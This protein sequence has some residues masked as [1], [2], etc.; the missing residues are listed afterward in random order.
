MKI[1]SIIK[2]NF[3]ILLRNKSS[4][5][6]VLLGPLLIILI[7][8][9]AFSN[10]GSDYALKIGVYSSE[11]SN[12]TDNFITSLEQSYEINKLNDNESCINSVIKGDNNACLIFPAN[13]Q[14]EDETQDEIQLYIDQSRINLVDAIV[15]RIS[16][17]LGVSSESTSK[18]LTTSLLTAITLTKDEIEQ[19]LLKGIN[20]KQKTDSLISDTSSISSQVNSMDLSMGS[21]DIGDID[22]EVDTLYSRA[23][24]IKTKALDAIDKALD[25]L[26]DVGYSANDSANYKDYISL[27]SSYATIESS[28]I[29]SSYNTIIS[30]LDSATE[31]IE[32]LEDKLSSAQTKQSDTVTKLGN[33]KTNLESVKSDISDLK[34]SLEK[35]KDSIS[36]IKVMNAEN[37]IN[38][39]TTTINPVATTSKKGSFLLP[40]LVVLVIMFIGIMLSGTSIV[41]DK[42]SPAAFRTFASPTKDSTYL[43]S[44][45]LT[46][47]IILLVQIGIIGGLA[48]LFMKFDFTGNIFVSALI[49][50]LAS[51]FFIL[52]GMGFGYLLKSQEAVTIAS[53]SLSAILLFVSNLII[54]LETTPLII[55]KI[56]A[57]NPYVLLSEALKKSMI[58][59]VKLL[60]IIRELGLILIY[61]LVVIVLIF[62]IQK[63]SKIIF[64]KKIHLLHKRT[65]VEELSEEN[66][67]RLKD[68]KIIKDKKGLLTFLQKCDNSEYREFVNH[69]KN[70]FADW[71][72]NSLGDKKIAKKLKKV[73]DKKEMIQIIEDNIAKNLINK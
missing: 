26:I 48:F 29:N 67:F 70:E 31:E 64:F 40:Y 16:S 37:I 28:A 38:P 44:Y 59:N 9:L 66:I 4:A 23:N 50:I 43:F 18:D 57:Y 45:Y 71:L 49:I 55:Q 51:S 11:Y 68:G 22:S 52:I 21:V 62:I 8:G 46:N 32:D 72:S 54:P 60:E 12:A 10:L 14:L 35:I 69:Q 1:F 19:D 41:I 27:N 47:I 15:N 3:K 36:A 5:L 73:T 17:I 56:A 2:K 25:I 34:S 6:I 39:I 63:L 33:V 42:T 61:I 13:I 30:S 7:V 65:N 20:I 58:F 53:L 24:S